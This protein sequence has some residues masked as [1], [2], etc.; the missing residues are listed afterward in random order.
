[1]IVA[2][3]G[4][5][6]PFDRLLRALANYALRHP[7]EEVWVQYL[8][9][10]LP[11]PLKGVPAL[12]RTQLLDRMRAA[13]V[14]V[15]HAGCGTIADAFETGHV[16]VI[17]PRRAHLGEHVNDHQMELA[18]VLERDNRIIVLHDTARLTQAIE[19]ARV[20][21]NPERS[22]V[23]RDRLKAVLRAEIERRDH[24]GQRP[25][26]TRAWAA[27]R[28]LTSLVRAEVSHT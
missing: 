12:P 22:F 11:E 28:A 16:P 7:G 2:V 20:R 1:M 17:I 6:T 5:G 3:T 26:T 25:R 10:K 27:L 23:Q 8:D 19:S 4:T 21:R 9:A 14:V 24:G 18:N 13:D 15:A